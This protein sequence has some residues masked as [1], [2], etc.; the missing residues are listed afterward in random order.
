M[1][2]INIFRT[3]FKQAIEDDLNTPEAIAV[4][5]SIIKSNIPSEDKYDLLKEFDTILSLDL[6]LTENLSSQSSIPEEIK[7][8]AQERETSRNNKD[9]KESDRLRD[10]ISQKGFLIEDKGD[11]YE[12]KKS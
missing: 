11:R 7:K 5:W 12:I 2:K 3:Q 1:D 8:L 10:L 6:D 9:F 4:V